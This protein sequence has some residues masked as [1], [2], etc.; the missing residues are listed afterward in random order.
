MLQPQRGAVNVPVLTAAE[1]AVQQLPPAV[2]AVAAVLPAADEQPDAGQQPAHEGE[3]EG[4]ARSESR[5]C[6]AGC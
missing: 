1:G 3:E 5:V 6:N 2:C 4:C